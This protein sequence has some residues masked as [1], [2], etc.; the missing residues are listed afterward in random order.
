MRQTGVEQKR[1]KTA[2]T[3]ELQGLKSSKYDS[4]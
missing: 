4:R 3:F 2:Y 1:K